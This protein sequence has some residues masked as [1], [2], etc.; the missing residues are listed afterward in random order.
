MNEIKPGTR[1]RFKEPMPEEVG[2]EMVCVQDRG[3][4]VLCS[5]P[6][7]FEGRGLITPVQTLLK[8]DVEVI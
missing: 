5:F 1:L 3:E 6:K 8:E 4:R 2:I 7:L